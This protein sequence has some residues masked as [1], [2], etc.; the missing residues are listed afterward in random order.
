MSRS[1]LVKYKGKTIADLGRTINPSIFSARGE[2]LPIATW[3][4][5]LVDE[6]LSVREQF[7]KTIVALA[8]HHPT[9]DEV[10]EIVEEIDHLVEDYVSMFSEIAVARIILDLSDNEDVD[11][12][13]K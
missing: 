8:A 6:E 11:V 10:E 13:L 1:T 5:I 7:T 4:K 12:E 9:K 3:R 2:N